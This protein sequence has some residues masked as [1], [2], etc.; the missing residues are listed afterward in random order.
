[1]NEVKDERRDELRFKNQLRTMQIIAIAM[2]AGVCVFATIVVFQV[3][4]RQNDPAKAAVQGELPLP[5]LAA[6]ALAA[7]GPLAFLLLRSTLKKIADGTWTPPSAR[8]GG[9]WPPGYFDG[10]EIKL[11]FDRQRSFIIGMAM[12]EG[13]GFFGCMAYMVSGQPLALGVIVGAI[14]LMLCKFP[15]AG[16]LRNWIELQA[17]RLTDLRRE[18]D[19]MPPRT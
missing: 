3:S 13:T 5:Q 9:T 18:R 15:T 11:L 12:L 19:L 7:F 1:M 16:R 4:T 8:N 10:D 14:F 17:A 6:G 2:L